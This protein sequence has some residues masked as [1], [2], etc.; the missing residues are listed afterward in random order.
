MQNEPAF[1]DANI[2]I[3][4]ARKRKGWKA[5]ALA[6]TEIKKLNG[7]VSSLTVAIIYFI[8]LRTM[9]ALKAR[10]ETRELI[11]GLGVVAVTPDAVNQAFD[12]VSIEDFEDALQFYCAKAA[13]KTIV[14]RNKRDYEAAETELQVMTPEEFLARL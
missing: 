9:P 6:L 13:A 4:V 11:Q 14:T 1:V 12:N 3:D 2:F 7:V 8:K 5:S 10:Q